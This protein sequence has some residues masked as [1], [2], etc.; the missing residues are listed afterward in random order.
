LLNPLKGT[1]RVRGRGITADP[2]GNVYVLWEDL[3]DGDRGDAFNH[4]YLYGPD[5][6]RKKEKLIEGHIRAMDSVRVDLAGNV[7]LA[8]ALRPGQELVPGWLK[9]QVPPGPKDPDA[10]GELNIYPLLYG[11][12]AKFGPEGGLIR[13][14]CQGVPCN[15]AFGKAMEVK[16]AKWIFSGASPAVSWRTPGTPDICN[17][18]SARFDVDGFGRCFFPDAAGC[19]VGVL[20]TN[21]NLL[22]WFGGYGNADSAGPGSRVPLPA[23]PL[24]WPYGVAVGDGRV[25]VGDRL[26]RRVV[27][28][29]LAYSASE[30]I[31]LR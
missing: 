22:R 7:Y 18:E 13:P 12:I 17:C 14:E 29:Q 23:I 31:P 21:G 4:V 27:C 30:T 8:L 2:A 26:N 6:A 28:V 5:G 24:H 16:G 19:R 11:S 1:H 15:Y 10:V 3:L 20:D 25:Y 9:G